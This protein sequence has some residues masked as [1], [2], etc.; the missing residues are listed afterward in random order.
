MITKKLHFEQ[1]ITKAGTLKYP[2]SQTL[3]QGENLWALVKSILGNFNNDYIKEAVEKVAEWNG[4][5]IPEWGINNCTKDARKLLT[6]SVI[7][8]IPLDEYLKR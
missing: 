6:G 5:N 2:K 4:I 7:D 1:I 3:K 8:L